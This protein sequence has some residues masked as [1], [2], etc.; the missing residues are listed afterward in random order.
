MSCKDDLQL[1]EGVLL[2]PEKI[3]EFVDWLEEE[4]LVLVVFRKVISVR[5]AYNPLLK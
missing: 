5:I 1:P 3:V 2:D 4:N